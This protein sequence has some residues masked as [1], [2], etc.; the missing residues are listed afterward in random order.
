MAL[1]Q[2]EAQRKYPSVTIENTELRIVV[3]KN[4]PNQTFQIKIDLPESYSKSDTIHYPVLY[5]TDADF[6]FG[7]ASDM[8]DYLRWGGFMPEVIIVGIAYG[9]KDRE[10]GNMRS[11]DFRPYPDAEGIVGASRFLKFITDELFPM[12]ETNYRVEMNDKTLFGVSAGGRFATYVLFIS[13]DIF[14]RYIINSPVL[15]DANNW[16]FRLEEEFFNKKKDISARVYMSMGE[17]ESYYPPFPHFIKII[18]SRN[19]SGLEFKH[20]LLNRGRH[21]SVIS[22]ALS[23]GLKYV[24][25]EES[26]YELMI[27]HINEKNVQLAIDQYKKLKQTFPKKYNFHED[28][29]N[30]LGYFLLKMKRFDDAIEIFKLNIEA[31]PTSANTYDSMA[32]AYMEI[33]NKEMTIKYANKTLEVISKYPQPD[34]KRIKGWA[35]EKLNKLKTNVKNK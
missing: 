10:G 30:N 32:D 11:R 6:L 14:N 16:A 1:G 31:Y 17:V 20:E 7:I 12:I 33:G 8:V 13:P 22:E 3:S 19:Y 2:S 25:S 27:K 18:E 24:Y 15:D 4:V 26:I 21:F 35:L 28:E 9:S 5:L 34:S 23:R 29:L